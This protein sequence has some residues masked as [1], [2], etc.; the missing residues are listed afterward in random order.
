[1][2]ELWLG[3]EYSL[4][5]YL[6]TLQSIEALQMAPK[7]YNPTQED[8]QPEEDLPF[9]LEVVD[10]IGVIN[11][12][13][14]IISKSS[15]WSQYLEV[16]SYPDIREAL[17]A[18]TNDS[19]VH[20]IL[21]NIDSPGGSA[22]GVDDVGTLIAQIN[23]DHVSV[24]AYSKGSMDSAAYW[25]AASAGRIYSSRLASVGSIGVITTH[26]DVTK[27]LEMD[28]VKPTV[29]RAGEF[30]ALGGPYETLSDTAKQIIQTHLEVIYNEFIAQVASGRRVSTETVR[31]TMADGREFFGF[32]AAAA[33]L[34]DGVMSL[35][36]MFLK[37]Q[38]ENQAN[39]L[40]Y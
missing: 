22:N 13:G 27:Q 24:D 9:M 14:P 36:Q 35:D 18:A 1:M 20:S 31:N 33:G 28:G 8:Q 23:R 2:F 34:T 25:L 37:L 12:S 29:F 7:L 32:Q 15:W 16:A 39:S 26:F 40:N 6:Q 3:Q 4:P 19:S 30:K 11:I 17:I 5:L 38:S 10:G 21:L